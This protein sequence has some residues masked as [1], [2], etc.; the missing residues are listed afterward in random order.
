MELIQISLANA[1]VLIW[2]G[3]NLGMGLT[4]GYLF[5]VAAG[6]ILTYFTAPKSSNKDVEKLFQDFL[7]KKEE[8]ENKGE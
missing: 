3:I 7:K 5:I 2:T 8:D 1:R 6:A 4:L